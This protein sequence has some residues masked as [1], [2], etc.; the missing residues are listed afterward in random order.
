MT[1]E[2]NAVMPNLANFLYTFILIKKCKKFPAPLS[3]QNYNYAGRRRHLMYINLPIFMKPIQIYIYSFTVAYF[4][5]GRNTKAPDFKA[6][7]KKVH[8]L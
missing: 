3:M 7:D 2:K 4:C 8:I 5:D 1:A 6:T